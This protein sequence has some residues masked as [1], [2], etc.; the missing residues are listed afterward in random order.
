[1]DNVL[2]PPGSQNFGKAEANMAFGHHLHR[3]TAD[4][5]IEGRQYFVVET[6]N[7]AGMFYFKFIGVPQSL[8][9]R[10]QSTDAEGNQLP[11]NYAGDSFLLFH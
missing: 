5:H 8:A 3:I 6:D 1:M 11:E 9:D 7:D 4:Q 10:E 2:V